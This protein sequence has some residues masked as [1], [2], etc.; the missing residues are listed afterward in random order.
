MHLNKMNEWNGG[1]EGPELSL[2]YKESDME[3]NH[4]SF[5]QSVNMETEP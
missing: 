3:G 2:I 4:T 5:C 1:Q